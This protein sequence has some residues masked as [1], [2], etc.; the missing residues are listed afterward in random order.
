VSKSLL[1]NQLQEFID[2]LLPVLDGDLGEIQRKAYDEGLPIISPHTVS[3]LSTLLTLKYPRNVLEIGCG[4]GFSAA[5]FSRFLVG[6]GT[7]TT[8]E[9]YDFMAKRA[10]NNFQKL[11]ISDSITLIQEDAATALPKLVEADE[12]FDFIFMDCAK[13]QYLNFYTHCVELLATDGILVVDD[14]LQNGTIAW[15]RS[16]I[17]KRQR[18]THRN[19]NEFLSVA[20]SAKGFSSSILPIGDG[21]LLCVKE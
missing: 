21:V 5:L 12:R 2:G 19:L 1:D 11:G 17:L 14:V 4:I 3:F 7:V 13:S 10:V 8:I 6:G 18:T 20:M 15:E 16:E 9:R